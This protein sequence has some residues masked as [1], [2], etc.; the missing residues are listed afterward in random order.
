MSNLNLGFLASHNGSNMQAIIDAC[1]QGRLNARP[2][3]VISNNADS[4]ALQRAKKEGIPNY[5]LNNNIYSSDQEL[6]KEILDVLQNQSVDL[7]ILAGYMKK[8]GPMVLAAYKG[9]VLNIHPALLPKYGGQGMY[10]R[11]VHEAV[12]AAKEK[13]SGATIH[14]VD[15]EY[16]RGKII[17]QCQVPVY[18]NDD[19][20]SLSKR[21]LQ[22]EHELFVETL[23]KISEGEIKL[24]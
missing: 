2:C 14:I 23:Q 9:R 7:V 1:K 20:E 18:G 24:T 16:D 22:K 10:G 8:I 13:V 17:S 19:V 11:N 6:D 15:E 5:C 3:I 12:L 21:V 4:M